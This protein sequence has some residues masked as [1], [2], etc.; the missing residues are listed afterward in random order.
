MRLDDFNVSSIKTA[1]II[2]KI[3][4]LCSTWSV[5]EREENILHRKLQRLN[6]K[7]VKVS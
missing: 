6:S 4:K 1:I 2:D 3:L 7:A 5:R